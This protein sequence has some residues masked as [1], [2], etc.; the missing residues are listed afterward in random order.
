LAQLAA[1]HEQMTC[2]ITNKLRGAELDILDKIA[3]PPPR[4]P[5]GSARK[6]APL[7]LPS[8]PVR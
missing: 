3:A 4:L 7:T 2:D 5:E 8:P 1:G 6:P